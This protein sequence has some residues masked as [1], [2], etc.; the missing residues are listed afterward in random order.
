MVARIHAAFPFIGKEHPIIWITTFCH[1][2][3]SWWIFERSHFFA[4][5]IFNTHPNPKWLVT[6]AMHIK[7]S[8][9]TSRLGGKSARPEQLETLATG[10]LAEKH[11]LQAKGD[12]LSRE[13]CSWPQWNSHISPEKRDKGKQDAATR[14]NCSPLRVDRAFYGTVYHQPISGWASLAYFSGKA[15]EPHC[16][17]SSRPAPSQGQDWHYLCGQGLAN[18]AT[19]MAPR[20][21]WLSIPGDH[22]NSQEFFFFLRESREVCSPLSSWEWTSR[23]NCFKTQWASW[24]LCVVSSEKRDEPDGR[25]R[26]LWFV[27]RRPSRE[28]G[29]TLGERKENIVDVRGKRVEKQSITEGQK[30]EIDKWRV[31]WTVNVKLN[32]QPFSLV[33][34]C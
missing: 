28:S 23:L 6:A 10:G 2:F 33:P 34:H 14:K 24:C 3:T 30:A 16:H 4:Y 9:A 31:K 22:I 7:G 20:G 11:G 21:W 5:C 19:V 27:S 18:S 8:V 26:K 32:S 15:M 17:D 29:V 12:T 1:L 25:R 13:V